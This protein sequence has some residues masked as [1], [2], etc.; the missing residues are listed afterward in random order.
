MM[1]RL[2]KRFFIW[3]SW[4]LIL[5]LIM[6]AFAAEETGSLTLHYVLENYT[7]RLYHVAA[8]AEDGSFRLNEKYDSL[9]V[10]W[11][12][13]EQEDWYE[14]SVNLDTLVIAQDILADRIMVTDETGTA[15]AENLPYGLWLISGG[16]EKRDQTI[17][18]TQPLLVSIPGQTDSGTIHAHRDLTISKYSEEKQP[19]RIKL[20]VI[21]IWED[22]K[23]AA[24]PES[25][26]VTLLCDEEPYEMITLQAENDW[27]YVWENL[28]PDHSWRVAENEVPDG[29]TVSY[30]RDG[31]M[32][33]ITNTDSTPPPPHLPQTGVNYTPVIVLAP[34]SLMCL[35]IGF[36]R[37]RHSEA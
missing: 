14:L 21:K 37:R 25:I 7:F 6:P 17:Y 13:M 15:K 5:F 29:Y 31:Y 1:N 27:R 23:S 28:E 30:S 20:L 36:W 32:L 3:L 24:R 34:L 22:K 2:N 18:T 35:L 8:F 16:T 19:D 33:L 11:G 10:D 26:R 4:I 9:P 12:T